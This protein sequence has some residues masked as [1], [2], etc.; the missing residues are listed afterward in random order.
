MALRIYGIAKS[1]A[2][3][4]DLL[5]SKLTK[6]LDFYKEPARKA[7]KTRAARKKAQGAKEEGEEETTN[8]PISQ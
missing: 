2:K 7:A 1:M 8:P 4:D 3:H 6:A 5:R